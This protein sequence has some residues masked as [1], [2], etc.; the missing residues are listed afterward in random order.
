MPSPDSSHNSNEG[1]RVHGH[2]PPTVRRNL[3]VYCTRSFKRAEHLQRHIRTH[4]KD[5]PYVCQCGTAF[6]RRD[7][8][9]RHERLSHGHS[10]SHQGVQKS[11][12]YEDSTGDAVVQS[13]TETRSVAGVS[14]SRWTAPNSN[15]GIGSQ[16]PQR[17]QSETIYQNFSDD[18]LSAL[19]RTTRPVH[20]VPDGA[21]ADQ[22]YGQSMSRHDGDTPLS[23]EATFNFFNDDGH[24]FQE[25][26]SF[27]DSIG[28][29]A[30]WT[31][32]DFTHEVNTNG[33]DTEGHDKRESNNLRSTNDESCPGSPFGSWPPSVPQGDH[34]LTSISDTDP[35]DSNFKT[36]SLR[37]DSDIRARFNAS[38]ERYHDIIPDFVLPS[39]HTLTRY[40][41]SFFGGFHSHLQF[42]H[43]P[44]FRPG[45]CP[46]ELI[47]AV[48]ATGAQYCFEHRNSRTLFR[49]SKAI[50]LA[51]L[52]QREI[53]V[54]QRAGSMLSPLN[55]GSRP[56]QQ[57]PGPHFSTVVSSNSE[58]PNSTL[59]KEM[60]TIRCLLI[61]MG[62]ATWEDS[63]LLHEALNLQS[64]LVHCL[65]EEGLRETVGPNSSSANLSW[66]EWSEQESVRRTK[67][68][69]FTFIH[70]HSIAYN[71]YPALRS[72]EIYLRLPCSTREW[73]AQTA[74]QWQAARRDVKAEQLHYQDALSRLL[75]NSGSNA[76]INPTPAPLGNYI[77]LHGL[78]QRIHLIRELSLSA[79]DY[80]TALPDEELNKI[81]R[82]LR[83]WTLVW[84]QA[85][86]SSLDPSNENGPIPFTSSALLGLAYIRACM[87]LGPHRAL[88]TRN[89]LLIAA[90]ISKAPSPSRGRFLIP[91]LIYSTHALS[92]PVRLGI[93]SV[94]RSQAFFWSVRHCLSSL[95]CAVFLSKWLCSLSELHDT[96]PLSENENRIL[97]WV[98]AIV[99]EAISYLDIDKADIGI[100]V[101]ISRPHTLG[102]AVSRLWARLFMHNVQWP[103]INIIGQG[104]QKYSETLQAG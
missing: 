73:N 8:L 55:L 10:S 49:T 19:S 80:S 92:I 71:V 53:A 86:E 20:S 14:V 31:P 77:L 99:Q 2:R 78:L 98:N 15:E 50:V 48:C 7:L 58:H 76:H 43:A 35:H 51:N 74:A 61:L 52:S 41:K 94:A 63:E 24:H 102:L 85:P 96:Q 100:D 90:G 69:S 16:W 28:L 37:V 62:Y 39:R 60:D 97:R 4:T 3:C 70:V 25:F 89:P 64:L 6:A 32:P 72:N 57:P 91:A 22:Q 93:D 47:L 18:A 9:T 95:E 33:A 83:S 54:S 38:L 67:L 79:L 65:R 88:E 34:P 26:A 84:K 103:F 104:L 29:P 21:V 17:E 1:R 45:N 44:T 59:Y 5:K 12:D 36:Y 82:A 68:V 66:T 30:E 46:I 81:E 11:A 56:I 13:L 27:L 23:P 40:I 42:L 101:D 75:T 87:N